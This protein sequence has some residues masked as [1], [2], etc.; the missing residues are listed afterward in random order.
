V[1]IF[2]DAE[3]SD[4]LD[5]LSRYRTSLLNNMFRILR[6]LEAEQKLTKVIDA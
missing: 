6:L 4:T 2:L 3:K 5:K 1:N